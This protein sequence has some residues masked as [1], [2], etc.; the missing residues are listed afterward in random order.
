MSTSFPPN[1]DGLLRLASIFTRVASDLRFYTW[2]AKS[3]FMLSIVLQR[4]HLHHIIFGLVPSEYR[5]GVSLRIIR[6]P[7]TPL[8]SMVIS[9]KRNILLYIVYNNRGKIIYFYTFH[10]LHSPLIIAMT[11][12]MFQ[13]K[14]EPHVPRCRGSRG[15]L[16]LNVAAFWDT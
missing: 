8:A 9:I 14:Q 6:Q 10:T 5:R 1:L 13:R 12:L 11:P 3:L 16:P 7:D 4:L 2:A 15:F